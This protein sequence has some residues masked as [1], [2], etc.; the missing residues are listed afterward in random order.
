[1]TAQFL[2]WFLMG[3]ISA[4][5]TLSVVAVKLYFLAILAPMAAL[6]ALFFVSARWRIIAYFCGWLAGIVRALW[7]EPWVVGWPWWHSLEVGLSNIVGRLNAVFQGIFPDPIAGFSQGII[8]GGKDVRFSQEFYQA[9]RATSTM[10][11]VAVSGYNVSLIG[12]YIQNILVWCGI[13]RKIIWIFALL[14]LWLFVVFVG[15]PSSAAR[16]GIMVS[17]FIVAER[18]GR[19]GQAWRILVYA[20]ALMLLQN[21]GALFDLGFQLSFLA[22]AGIIMAAVYSS[23][24][25]RASG[26]IRETLW[27]QLM[28]FP[29]IAHTFGTVPLLGIVANLAIIPLMPLLM[30]ASLTPAVFGIIHL[31][32]GK[33]LGLMVL[34]L[35]WLAIKGIE[36][37]ARLPLAS[38]NIPG[39]GAGLLVVYYGAILAYG[40][41]VYKHS[42]AGK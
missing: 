11:L 25:G 17:L 38:I 31:G 19:T 20:L 18:F 10:H 33:I 39:F 37:S 13:H 28:V 2:L 16:A 24:Q 14:G 30:I 29:L 8:T 9:L 15:V 40:L 41:F 26:I 3:L 35:L 32:L 7:P 42:F 27:A 21:P 34:P 4:I 22:T 1:M 23:S 6:A 36:T 5:M 12:R